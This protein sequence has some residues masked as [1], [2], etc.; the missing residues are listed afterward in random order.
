[1]NNLNEKILIERAEKFEQYVHAHNNDNLPIDFNNS[2]GILYREEDYKKRIAR[3]ARSVLTSENWDDSWIGDGRIQQSINRV[4]DLSGNLVNFNTRIDF[5]KRFEEYKSDAE[6]AIYDIYRSS[7]DK[8]AFEQA[9]KIFGAKYPVVAY[10]FFVKDEEKY[11]PTSP[12][13]FDRCFRELDIDFKMS[14]SCSW[15]NYCEF[16]EII[17]DI[18]NRLNTYIDVAHEV[19]LLDAHSF[20]WI[21]GEK[22]FIEWNPDR[23]DINI[24]RKP[25]EIIAQPDGTMKYQCANCGN[26]FK[27]ADRCPECGQAVMR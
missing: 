3:Q 26:Y 22:K 13:G 23:S 17:R 11:L 8:R 12:Q 19:S 25:G 15:D 24:P 10:L 1:M 4:M 14:F 18:G 21:L 2:E 9:I 16:I 7:D 27:A 5:R 6:K 20:V